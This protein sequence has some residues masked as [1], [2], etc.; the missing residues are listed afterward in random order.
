MGLVGG[1]RGRRTVFLTSGC[2]LLMIIIVS[3]SVLGSKH[4][5]VNISRFF[6]L[7]QHN[8]RVKC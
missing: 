3:G 6:P 7:N 1:T 4:R 2:V 8:Y 5:K